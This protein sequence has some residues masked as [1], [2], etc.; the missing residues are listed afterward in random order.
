MLTV[1]QQPRCSTAGQTRHNTHF[2]VNVAL[3]TVGPSA[4][5]NKLHAALGIWF[6]ILH[7]L[8]TLLLSLLEVWQGALQLKDAAHIP[9]LDT[10]FFLQEEIKPSQ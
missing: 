7:R 3:V 5:C 10:F 4:Y 1:L 6:C 2:S 9:S 8:R